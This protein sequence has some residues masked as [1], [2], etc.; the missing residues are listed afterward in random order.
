M[1]NGINQG[2]EGSQD[3]GKTWLLRKVEVGAQLLVAVDVE[4]TG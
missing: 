3:V 1:I 2:N 4:S